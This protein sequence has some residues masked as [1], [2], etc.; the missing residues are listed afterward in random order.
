MKEGASSRAL[1]LFDPVS[2]SQHL[3]IPAGA[4]LELLFRGDGHREVIQGP[5]IVLIEANR[6]RVIGGKPKVEKQAPVLGRTLVA[7]SGTLDA[8]GGHVDKGVSPGGGGGVLE[9]QDK[10]KSS[11][12]FQL[13]ED[14]KLET[15]WGVEP[16]L[17]KMSLEWKPER[18]WE[19]VALPNASLESVQLLLTDAST[20]K[21]VRTLPA[22]Q[23]V[24]LESAL[25][26]DTLY[27]L[28]V[29]SEGQINDILLVRRLSHK[30]GQSLQGFSQL[31]AKERRQ[32]AEQLSLHHLAAGAVE[33]QLHQKPDA[34]L[35]QYLV[36]YYDYIAQWPQGVQ[37]WQTWGEGQGMR[38]RDSR[39]RRGPGEPL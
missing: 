26:A 14:P 16:P 13:R 20:D 39:E 35:L 37:Y 5:G 32:R 10:P 11:K 34:E 33:E 25:K 21:F 28:V 7:R 31:D 8:I 3:N 38:T 27:R 4:R 1:H 19:V 24:P 30:E 18:G 9:R 2:P 12:V 36:D 23:R 17:P 22:A 6:C 29:I 15:P